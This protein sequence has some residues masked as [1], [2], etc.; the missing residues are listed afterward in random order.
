[1]FLKFFFRRLLFS[2]PT[3]FGVATLAFLLGQLIP[4]D[5]AIAA[6]GLDLDGFSTVDPEELER[7]RTEL[8]LDRPVFLQYVSWLGHALQGDLGRSSVNNEPVIA[9]ILR[10]LPN[11][12]LLLFMTIVSASIIGVILGVVSAIHR[13]KTTDFVARMIAII[14]VSTPTFWLALVLILL[15]AFHLDLFPMN[16]SVAE[17]GFIALVLPTASIAMHPAALI[18][19]MTR[20]SMLE[21]LSQDMIRT[22]TAKGLSRWRVIFRH[23]LPNALSPVITVIGFQFANLVGGAVAVEVVFTMPGL[24]NLLI[25]SIFEN[26]LRVMQGVVL[27]VGITFALTNLGVDMLYAIIDPRIEL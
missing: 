26:D 5:P 11:T 10:A 12:M 21:V 24:G 20:S 16:G 17:H 6:L 14:G 18:A 22:A 9:L 3:I 27:I 2:V 7:V 1:M 8:G 23:G 15:F 4:G 25:N 19:R 13:G